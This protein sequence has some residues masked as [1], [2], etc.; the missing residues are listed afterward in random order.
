MP[1][2]A[3]LVEPSAAR[4]DSYAITVHFGGE[5]MADTD[6][7]VFV[8][9]EDE[10]SSEDSVDATLD[11]GSTNSD[12]SKYVTVSF[13]EPGT[14]KA[15]IRADTISD[16]WDDVGSVTLVGACDVWCG[17]WCGMWCGVWC[18]VWCDRVAGGGRAC[19]AR[20]TGAACD[21]GASW[22]YSWR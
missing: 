4:L 19:G 16:T 8:L 10:C 6:V 7:V 12:S 3:S 15:C 9:S 2:L 11:G 21:A 22:G 17:V 1:V 5:D 18:G 14:Y 13:T 20:R